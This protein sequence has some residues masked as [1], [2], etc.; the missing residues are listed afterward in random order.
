[1]DIKKYIGLTS[2][3]E[4]GYDFKITTHVPTPNVSDYQVGY[5]R[6]YFVQKRNDK[7][8]PIFE[9]SLNEY[10]RLVKEAL[11]IGATVKWRISGP[12]T[13]TIIDSVLDK[14]VRDSNRIA[15]SLVNDI[16]PNLKIYLPNL[17]QFHE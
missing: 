10:E 14:G 6:R 7:S 13:E 2:R 8:S 4:T 15:I 12:I 3:R 1:M 11:Y 17:L 5:I 9:V 16:M